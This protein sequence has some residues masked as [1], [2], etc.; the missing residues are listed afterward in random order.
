MC[1][2]NKHIKGFAYA[3]LGA[4]RSDFPH[5]KKQVGAAYVDGSRIIIA[6][7]SLKTAPIAKR[8]GSRYFRLHAE[9]NCLQGISDCSSGTLYVYREHKDGTFA[10]SRP[11]DI[12]IPL[13]K[14][15]GCR[16]V[17]YTTEGGAA[18]LDLRSL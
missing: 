18:S 4:L 17:Y 16:R 8:Y 10:M 14:Q 3:R 1:E 12:C 5:K 15:L 13:L 11:C 7:N 9:M 2:V 6:S